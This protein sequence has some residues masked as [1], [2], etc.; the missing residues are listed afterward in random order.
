MTSFFNLDA[1]YS[2]LK[3]K[4]IGR[5]CIYLDKI[6]STIDV[7]SCE[8]SGTIVLAKQQINGRGQRGNVW[9]SPLGCAMASLKLSCPKQSYLGSKLC[10]LQHIL[11]LMAARTLEQL[12]PRMLGKDAIGLKWPNDIVYKN[13]DVK[14]GQKIGGVLVNCRDDMLDF[15][16]TLSFGLNVFNREPTTCI[17]DILGPSRHISI[18]SVVAGMMNNLE[19]YLLDLDEERFAELKE[20]YVDRC[21]HMKKCVEDENHGRAR[22]KELNDDGYLLGERCSDGKL[23]IITKIMSYDL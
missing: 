4:R 7:A 23:C 21:I 16:M 15:D 19:K 20:E 9:Q 12:D 5:P 10:F 22:V 6:S 14:Q 17:S 13:P 18:D 8:T 2:N 3:T 1:Y 11:V